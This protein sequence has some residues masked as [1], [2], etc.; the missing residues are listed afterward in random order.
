MPD[1]QSLPYRPCAGIALFNREGLVWI[2]RRVDGPDEAEGAGR[3]WQMP[4]G[5]IDA[6]EVPEA[7]ARRE[8][9]EETGVRTVSPLGEVPDWLTYDLPPNLLGKAWGGRFRGQKIKWVAFRFEGSEI[10]IDI[11]APGG[12]KHKPEFSSWRWERLERL[13]ELIVPFKKA[14]YDEVVT[15][16]GPFARPVGV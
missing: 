6:G 1:R 13:P 15:A 3:W 2:G 7:A 10:E 9:Y 12:G 14:M 8:L 16:L 11:H 5:G 4:Q